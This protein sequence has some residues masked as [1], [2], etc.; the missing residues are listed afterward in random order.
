VAPS[1]TCSSS[2][3]FPSATCSDPDHSSRGEPSPWKT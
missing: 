2:S 1:A 3:S